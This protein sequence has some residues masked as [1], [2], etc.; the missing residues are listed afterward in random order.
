[1]TRCA[2][3]MTMPHASR[4][5]ACALVALLAAGCGAQPKKTRPAAAQT[6]P[7]PVVAVVPKADKGDPQARF[8]E[9]LKMMKERQTKEAREAFLELAKDFPTFS[10]PFTDLAILQ[11]KGNQPTL[12]ISNFEKAIRL[13][14][15]NAMAWN[16]LGTLHR[17]T[18]D[19]ARAEA[20]YKSALGL[21]PDY[22]ATHLNLGLLYELYLSRPQE[23]LGQYREYQRLTGG[24]KLIVSAWIRE[25]EAQ[26]PPPPPEP[27][28]ASPASPAAAPPAGA[29]KP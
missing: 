13:N 28:A 12:A 25:L 27:V 26:S 14:P 19:Y 8:D 4:W 17:E 18:K 23:A 29:R 21:K 22:A 11:A 24:S 7:A 5:L 9:A 1:M 3:P 2:E 6:G 20:A 16:W 10:G 15:D